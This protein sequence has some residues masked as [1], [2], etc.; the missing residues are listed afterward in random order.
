MNRDNA[1]TARDVGEAAM[2]AGDHTKA[3]RMFLKSKQLFPLEGI[4]ARIAAARSATQPNNNQRQ[5]QEQQQQSSSSSSSTSSTST[6]STA[7]SSRSA[8]AP[9]SSSASSTADVAPEQVECVRRIV[10]TTCYYEVLQVTKGDITELEL[11]KGDFFFFF[12]FFLTS[13]KNRSLSQSG[14]SCA[15]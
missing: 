12:F 10:E 3:L 11:K 7:T 8:S 2:R 5:Q 1:E 14:S 9:A 4:D 13:L 15:S 6:A